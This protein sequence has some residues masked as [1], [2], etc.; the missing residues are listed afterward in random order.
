[1]KKTMSLILGMGILILSGC[2][3][4]PNIQRYGSVIGLK[5]ADLEE[6][7]RLHANAW[8]ELLKLLEEANIQNYSIYLTE[9]DDGNHYLFSYLEY[10]GS[11][12]A[13]D[14]NELGNHPVTKKWW[15]LTDP[16]QLPLKTRGTGEYWKAMDE[17][18]HMN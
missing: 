3:S 14:F 2:R 12:V 15:A 17:V 7:N 18:F 16:M 11:D 1:V 13:G 8:P 9:F 4:T 5:T 10:T 6:Y